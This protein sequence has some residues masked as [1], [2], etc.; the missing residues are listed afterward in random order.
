M[1]YNVKD[2]SL[3]WSNYVT[4]MAIDICTVDNYTGDGYGQPFSM[5]ISK[6]KTVA[7]EK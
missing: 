4:E 2:L 7:S 5:N 1:V 3:V 6:N